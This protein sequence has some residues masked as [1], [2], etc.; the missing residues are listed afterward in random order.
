M[1]LFDHL[2]N[3]RAKA[4]EPMFSEFIDSVRSTIPHR[5]KPLLEPVKSFHEL[6]NT[7]NS[8]IG[9]REALESASEPFC[10]R[11]DAKPGFWEQYADFEALEAINTSSTQQC[12]HHCSVAVSAAALSKACDG[13][14]DALDSSLAMVEALA[15]FCVKHAAGLDASAEEQ[16]AKG[17][18]LTERVKQKRARAKERVYN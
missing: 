16:R 14:S 8:K 9:L 4:L 3:A 1:Q 17:R 10:K 13:A 11:Y 12:H 7:L 15:N 2:H 18:V 5:Y 6:N